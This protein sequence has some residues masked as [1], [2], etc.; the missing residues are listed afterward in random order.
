MIR[1]VASAIPEFP[2]DRDDVV[3]IM[4]ALFDIRAD[5]E[6]IFS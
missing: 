2:L 5:V 6:T 4:G 3:S 1:Q